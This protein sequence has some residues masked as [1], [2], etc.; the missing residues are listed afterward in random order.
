MSARVISSMAANE[1]A[2]PIC[3]LRFLTFSHGSPALFE[4]VS[5]CST[6]A[7]SQRTSRRDE[8]CI[9]LN[10]NNKREGWMEGRKEGMRDGCTD[11]WFVIKQ[12]QEN[13]GCR[14]GGSYMSLL[15]NFIVPGTPGCWKMEVALQE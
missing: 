7:E 2:S 13:T 5:L 8:D 14:V 10:Q 1:K 3:R 12:I 4:M 6:G 9:W 11:E 15:T